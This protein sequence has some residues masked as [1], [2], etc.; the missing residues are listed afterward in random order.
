MLY[1][2][3]FRKKPAICEFDWPFTPNLKSSQYFATHTGSVLQKIL[4]FLQPVQS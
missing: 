3:R 2:D 1:L 4:L